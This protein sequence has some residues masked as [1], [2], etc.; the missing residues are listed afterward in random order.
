MRIVERKCKRVYATPETTTGLQN[1]RYLLSIYK[2]GYPTCYL[3]M[4]HL[5]GSHNDATEAAGVL[6]DGHAVHLLQ[7]LVHHA[8]AA[9]IGKACGPR[10][11][12][13]NMLTT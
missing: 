6:N 7:P 4:S 3:Q 8:C 10:R 12:A 5:V 13:E 11:E 9:D 1:Y 2:V